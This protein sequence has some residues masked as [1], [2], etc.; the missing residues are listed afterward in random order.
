MATHSDA[1]DT[2]STA[3]GEGCDGAI[4]ALRRLHGEIDAEAAAVARRNPGRLRCGRACADCCVDDLEVFE[5]EAQ[6]IR[7]IHADLLANEEP[8]SP[9]ACAFLDADRCCRIYPERPYVCRTQG[10]PL[11]WYEDPGGRGQATERRDICPLNGE[12]A[13]LENLSN[14]ACWT[15]GPVE[16]RLAAL[17]DRFDPGRP[18]RVRLRDLFRRRD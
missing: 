4:E 1:P 13:A 15:L 5:V 7:L 2:A 3:V 11:R 16:T 18:T 14:D 9:G 17:Q 8:R 12:G 6:N 10:L